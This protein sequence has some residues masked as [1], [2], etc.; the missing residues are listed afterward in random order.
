MNKVA[1]ISGT[2]PNLVKILSLCAEFKKQKVPFFCVYTGQHYDDKMSSDF[3]IEFNIKPDYILSPSKKT[4]IQQMSDIMV[5][6]E[7]ILLREKP[8][9]VV[10]VGDVNSTLAGALVAKKLNIKLAH[11]EAGLRSYNQK[12]PEEA[13]RVITD[14]L[15]DILFTSSEADIRTLKSEGIKRGV[16]FTGNIMIDALARFEKKLKINKSPEKFYYCTFHRAENIDDKKTFSGILDALEIIA[17]DHKLYLPLHPRTKKMAEIFHLSSRLNK[18]FSVLPPLSYTDSL[19]YQKNA[20]L[21]LTDSG[22]IQEESSY[23]G[24]PCLTIRTE[25]ERPITVTHGSNTLVGGTSIQLIL[26]AYRKKKLEKIQTEIP[27][28]D[29]KTSERIVK[30]LKKQNYV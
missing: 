8:K 18:I 1:I 20:K 13:N 15:A 25:T 21:I 28:W 24:V 9:L 19:Y 26:D 10:V 4:V 12:M 23:F 22:G 17:K 14:H 6:I 11:V 3:F 5:G 27:F 29:G 16:Y 30:I 2:R 7:K